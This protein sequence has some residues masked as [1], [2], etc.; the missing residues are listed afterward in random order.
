VK[1]KKDN[2][3]TLNDLDWLSTEDLANLSIE[4][5]AFL[6]AKLNEFNKINS[7][8]RVKLQTAIDHKFG[9]TMQD[10]LVDSGRDTGQVSLF[11]NEYRITRSVGKEVVWDQNKLIEALDQ[12]PT[13]IAKD[14]VKATFRINERKYLSCSNEIKEKLLASRTV[15]PRK[16]TYKIENKKETL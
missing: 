5:L 14:L 16:P 6:D 13:Q 1:S 15:M 11:D 4:E 12:I 8:R 2:S 9:V 7:E 10:M 3:S